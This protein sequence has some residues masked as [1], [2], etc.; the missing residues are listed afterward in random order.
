MKFGRAEL[1]SKDSYG[2]TPLMFAVQTQQNSAALFLLKNR[3][4]LGYIGKPQKC[5][6]SNG[7]ASRALIPP[8]A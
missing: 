3:Y 6:F 2:R 4:N 8:R 7:S 5:T 1:N